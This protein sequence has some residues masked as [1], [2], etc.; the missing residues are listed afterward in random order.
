MRLAP[1]SGA[2]RVVGPEGSVP[3]DGVMPVD[4][5]V[6]DHSVPHLA[7]RAYARILYVDRFLD[8]AAASAKAG[9]IEAAVTVA[10]RVGE[11]A[12]GYS[13]P[14]YDLATYLAALGRTEPALEALGRAIHLEPGFKV[15]CVDDPALAALHGEPGFRRLLEEPDGQ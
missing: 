6:E 13:R 2:L 9:D 14:F 15:V 11:G 10:T 7:L 1:R 3:G 8:D 12:P 5:R 4:V